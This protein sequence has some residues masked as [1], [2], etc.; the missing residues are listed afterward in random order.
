[1]EPL[2]VRRSA[3]LAGPPVQP[4]Q[5]A[6]H[7]SSECEGDHT[8]AGSGAGSAH[9]VS[10]TAASPNDTAGAVPAA[11]AAD[12][13]ALAANEAGSEQVAATNCA[14]PDAAG[15]A[16]S[17]ADAGLFRA[18]GA[19]EECDLRSLATR[20]G[21]GSDEVAEAVGA[22]VVQPTDHPGADD[23][24][25]SG[26]TG[27]GAPPGE[28]G[29]NGREQCCT[30][31]DDAP[32][33]QRV[34][35][36]VPDHATAVRQVQHADADG[37]EQLGGTGA[38]TATTGVAGEVDTGGKGAEAATLRVAAAGAAAAA[39]VGG[40]DQVPSDGQVVVLQT[41]QLAVA[42]QVCCMSVHLYG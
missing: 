3:R 6:T 36:A 4:P 12:H 37:G 32:A 24:T 42:A 31:G 7:S 8:Y 5:D 18:R 9:C 25:E 41:K 34:L 35:H 11:V 33:A 26:R 22:P 10:S 19:G 28:G 1:M 2:G 39:T 21:Q 13:G 27:S 29:Q 15:A 14:R 30:S 20:P 38:G 17:V 40:A 16:G 23:A